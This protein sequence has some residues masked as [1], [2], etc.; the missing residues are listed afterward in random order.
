MERAEIVDV[1]VLLGQEISDDF[2][3][4]TNCNLKSSMS[5]HFAMTPR[6]SVDK[7]YFSRTQNQKYNN[8]GYGLGVSW[9]FLKITTLASFLI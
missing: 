9:A 3:N 8:K 7:R 4:T 1:E 5:F 2:K 6:V